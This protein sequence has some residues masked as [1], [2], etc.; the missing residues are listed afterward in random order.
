MINCNR[1]NH[2]NKVQLLD[3]I[4]ILKMDGMIIEIQILFYCTILRSRHFI[5]KHFQQALKNNTI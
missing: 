3:V 4:S 2:K 1:K 5:Q